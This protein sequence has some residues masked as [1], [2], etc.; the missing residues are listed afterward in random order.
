MEI[1]QIKIGKL[2]C[3]PALAENILRV[4]REIFE[5]EG[6]EIKEGRNFLRILKLVFNV[7]I[8]AK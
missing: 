1:K 4:I 6:E 8:N 7:F 2:R 3:N 5:R